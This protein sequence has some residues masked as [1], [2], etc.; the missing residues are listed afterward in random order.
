MENSGG[1]PLLK[2]RRRLNMAEIVSGMSCASCAG[3]IEAILVQTPGIPQA[4][5]NFA[6]S[7]AAIEYDPQKIELL[8]IARLVKEMGYS[9]VIL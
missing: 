3:G 6:A 9:V 7:K 2:K 5:V 8:R 1:E 4:R